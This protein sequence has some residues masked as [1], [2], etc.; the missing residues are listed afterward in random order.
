MHD[1][2]CTIQLSWDSLLYTFAA[3]N[4]LSRALLYKR[5]GACFGCMPM[6]SAHSQVS[7]EARSLQSHMAS[8]QAAAVRQRT[9]IERS[10]TKAWLTISSIAPM[11]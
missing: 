1:I 10:Y 4:V 8:A 11:I 3:Y 9:F 5:Q 7:A 6:E 2:V